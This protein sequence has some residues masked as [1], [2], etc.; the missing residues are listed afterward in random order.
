MGRQ[1]ILKQLVLESYKTRSD[2]RKKEHKDKR[3]I[4]TDPLI[5]EKDDMECK[6]TPDG[7]MAC[8]KGQ[9]P[10]LGDVQDL[11]PFTFSL[12]SH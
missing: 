4:E 5:F 6:I 9:S 1:E 11:G 3:I 8:V 10:R 12:R 2:A 7:K